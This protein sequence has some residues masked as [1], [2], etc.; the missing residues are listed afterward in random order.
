MATNTTLA[1]FILTTAL[2]HLLGLQILSKAHHRAVDERGIAIPPPSPF[3]PN[4]H[5]LVLLQVT[6]SFHRTVDKL[7][8]G[9]VRRSVARDFLQVVLVET[10]PWM[11]DNKKSDGAF[12][13]DAIGEVVR[14]ASAA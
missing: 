8:C 6:D 11:Y 14:C 12:D 9:A 3:E 5:E 10:F 4:A 7:L 13:G 2:F 1:L